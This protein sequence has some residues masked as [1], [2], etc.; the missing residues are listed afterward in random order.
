MSLEIVRVFDEIVWF[1]ELE[2]VLF[3]FSGLVLRLFN[4][5]FFVL[6]WELK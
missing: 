1:I 5:F 6:I 2:L 3:K 4:E